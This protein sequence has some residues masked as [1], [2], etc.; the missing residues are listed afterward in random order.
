M[1]Y[2]ASPYT[3]PDPFVMEWRYLLAM[4]RMTE[5]LR[6]G[7]YV[8]GPIVHNHELRKLGGLP[9]TW[10]FWQGYD[11]DMLNRCDRVEVLMLP[12]WQQSVGVTAE[13]R[14]AADLRIPV[15]YETFKDP[16][17]EINPR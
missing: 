16:L 3:H 5:L 10:E 13:I 8:Y 12:G 15:T 7:L 17:R 11:F 6:Q 9:P 1:I 4:R 2:L 14:H